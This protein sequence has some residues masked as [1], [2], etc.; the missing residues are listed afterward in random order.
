MHLT[1]PRSQIFVAGH[2]GLVG[3]AVVR[4]LRAAGYKNLLLRSRAE[5]D[6]R[7]RGAVLALFED[8]RPEHVV[9]AA[10]TV[11]G[12][13]DHGARPADMI[14]DNLAIVRAVA[15]AARATRLGGRV[16]FLGTSAAYP[17]GAPQPMR[18]EHLWTGP[19]EP[20]VRSYAVAK[21]AGLELLEAY[22][23]QHGLDVI[24]LMP[25]NLYGP[26]DSFDLATAHVLPALVRRFHEA[27]GAGPGGTD[28]PV[29]LWGSGAA[30]RE[31]LFAD[32]L[33]R[34][35]RRVL[36][37]PEAD[38]RAVAPDGVLN[39]GSGEDLTIRDLAEVVREV[40]GSESEICW[41]WSKPDGA[42]RK[43]LDVGRLGRLGWAPRT[44]LREGL[45]ATYRAF[46][47]RAGS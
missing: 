38:L 19:L 24:T 11:G 29:T 6:L 17:R 8:E 15:E 21:L 42:L 2:R 1:D 13:L 34:A 30:Y 41:D 7:N 12:I 23:R 47:S 3:S 40:V 43:L 46:R 22:R 27:R 33:A 9:L 44:P 32:D 18:E 20:T 14:A 16:V 31:F 26:D 4:D 39:V 37:V 25:S 36:T 5:V 35:I 45:G 10:A 28:A